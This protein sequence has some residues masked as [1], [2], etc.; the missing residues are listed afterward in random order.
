[1]ATVS[2]PVSSLPGSKHVVPEGM[3][4]D[5]CKVNKAAVRIQ[6]ETDSMGAEFADVCATCEL[7]YN[8]AGMTGSCDWCGKD[9]T[10][11]KPARDYDEGVAG[12]VYYVCDACLTKQR[13]HAVEEY[14]QL[15]RD[16]APGSGEYYDMMYGGYED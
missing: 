3:M 9:S 7:K 8:N 12:P 5:S 10:E 6:G 15:S 16:Y 14:E 11:L 4:C 2:G 1:M 13:K